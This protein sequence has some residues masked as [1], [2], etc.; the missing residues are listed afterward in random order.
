MNIFTGRRRTAVLAAVGLVALAGILTSRFF[1]QDSTGSAGGGSHSPYV[2]LDRGTYGASPWYLFAQTQT[3]GGQRQL[4]MYI[5]GTPDSAALDT[6]DG[7]GKYLLGGT[8]GFNREYPDS[9]Y[10]DQAEILSGPQAGT[11]IVFG[12]LPDDAAQI[13]VAD[14]EVLPTHALPTERGLPAGRYWV[15]VEGS[16]WPSATDGAALGT[17]QPLNPGGLPVPFRSF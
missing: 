5:S 16:S 12:P 6:P 11:A 13:K 14:R 10:F 7:Q 9:S 2:L 3:T 17:P 8:C 4:C 1:G 15:S